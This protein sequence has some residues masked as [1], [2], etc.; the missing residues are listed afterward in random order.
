MTTLV[1]TGAVTYGVF[2]ELRGQ[3]ATIG[4]TLSVGISR[5]LPILVVGILYGLA[6]TL[7]LC[8]LCI[9]GFILLCMYYVATPATVVEEAGPFAAFGRSAELTDGNRW[10]ILAI[11][12]VLGV[13]VGGLSFV[14][15]FAAAA[16]SGGLSAVSVEN[17][18]AAVQL[19]TTLLKAPFAALQAIPPV[20]VYY[21]LRIG[22]EGADVEELVKVFE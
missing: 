16:L 22:K 8:A 19:G 13:L 15:A 18:Q 5:F 12:L 17:A 6:V 3:R 4:E 10:S 9:P 7:G 14:V 20:I 21:D 2:Q 1:V 11:I